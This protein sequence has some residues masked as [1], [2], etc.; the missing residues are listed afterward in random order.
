MVL[1]NLNTKLLKKKEGK[2]IKPLIEKSKN[3]QIGEIS[4]N[5]KCASNELKFKG[6]LNFNIV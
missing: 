2:E 4:K 5:G 1:L 6:S 3:Y